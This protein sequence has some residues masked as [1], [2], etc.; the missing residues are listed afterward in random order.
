[1]WIMFFVQ[2]DDTERCV[3]F[4]LFWLEKLASCH[5]H[6]FTLLVFLWHGE[7]CHKMP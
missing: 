6:L 1:M 5:A 3:Y 4:F 7:F 2:S